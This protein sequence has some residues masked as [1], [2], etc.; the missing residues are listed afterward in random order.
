[1]AKRTA[2]LSLRERLEDKNKIIVLPGVFDALSARIAEQVGF[3]AMFQTGYGSSA[4][5]LAMPD[6]GFLNAGETV[7]NARR[8]IRAVSVPVLV[9]ADTGYGNPLNVW[10]LVRDLES[11]GAAGIFLEDQVWPKRCGHMVG[12]DVIPKDDYL[13]KLKAAIDARRSEDF[14]IV[15]RTDARAPLGLEE[16]IERGK[17]YKKAGADVIFVE[18]PRSIEELKKVA[19]EIDAPLV[20]NMIEDGVTPTMSAQELLKIGYRIAVFPLSALYSAT[21]A[22]REVLTE[23]KNTGETKRTRKMMVT[24]KDFNRLVDLDNYMSLEKRYA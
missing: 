16:A 2:K 14:I 8:I 4:A 11:L 18:A 17:A 5:L 15:A 23:L 1:M 13:L 22:M 7:D 3:D 24:F 19:D 12:K 6:F 21:Y 10:R 20:A 9:D